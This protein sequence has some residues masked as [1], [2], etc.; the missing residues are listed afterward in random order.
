MTR[1]PRLARED[2]RPSRS[3][4]NGSQFTLRAARKH[5][6]AQGVT[7]RGYAIPSPSGAVIWSVREALRPGEPNGR[8]EKQPERIEAARVYRRRP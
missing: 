5:L 8:S 2:R 4:D 1:P 7:N 6:Y 3:A